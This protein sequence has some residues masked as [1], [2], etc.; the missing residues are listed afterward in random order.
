MP[1]PHPS[2]SEGSFIYSSGARKA[3]SPWRAVLFLLLL[4]GAFVAAWFAM[5]PALREFRT[6]QRLTADLPYVGMIAENAELLLAYP[7]ADLPRACGEMLEPL[8]DGEASL[9]AV[10]LWNAHGTLLSEVGRGDAATELPAPP[11]PPPLTEDRRGII[12]E[13]Q[14]LLAEQSGLSASM[15]AALQAEKGAGRHTGLYALQG[16]NLDLGKGL[17]QRVPRLRDALRDMDT[18]LEAL[19]H[20]DVDSLRAALRASQNAEAKVSLAL[21]E[22]R[23]V[24]DFPRPLPAALA[25]AAEDGDLLPLRARRVTA[26]LYKTTDD[27]LLAPAGAVE[28]IFYDRP[29]A[30]PL[31]AAR[32]VLAAPA[33]WLPSAALLLAALLVLIPRKRRAR[34]RH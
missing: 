8:F 30:A 32:H 7:P 21:E 25:D 19:S 34:F 27:T 11:P 13:L 12:F 22:L 3:G 33:R 5:T 17:R 16:L 14:Q 1:D 26:P 6:E 29:T 4:T 24:T 15:D 9:A 18:A 31:A 20:D 10:R 2:G 28:V 23:A